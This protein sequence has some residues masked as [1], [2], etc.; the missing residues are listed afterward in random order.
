MNLLMAKNL[1]IFVVQVLGHDDVSPLD[2]ISQARAIDSET[3]EEVELALDD[4]ARSD[5]EHLL[6]KHQE[7]VGKYLANH[8]ISRVTVTSDESLSEFIVRHLPNTGL[9]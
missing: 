4:A 2:G 1:D 9:V 3:G 7:D 8:N 5:Y 6:L